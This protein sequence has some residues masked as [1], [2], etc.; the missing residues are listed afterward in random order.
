ML[1]DDPQVVGER[2]VIVPG[3]GGTSRPEDA[4]E[5]HLGVERHPHRKVLSGVDFASEVVLDDLDD[6]GDAFGETWGRAW[7]EALDGLEK[8]LVYRR[9]QTIPAIKVEADQPGGDVGC[10]GDPLDREP[11]NPV[12]LDALHARFDE[13]TAADLG[14]R[15]NTLSLQFHWSTGQSGL[16]SPLRAL[17][18]LG[19]AAPVLVLKFSSR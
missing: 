6:D 8:V 7:L 17:P 5:L 12:L 10:L 15:A 9:K 13:L 14:R 16:P 18:E 19:F 4:V 11:G 3:Q 1:G 2:R